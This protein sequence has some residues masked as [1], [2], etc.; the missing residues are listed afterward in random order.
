MFESK[1]PLLS[2]TKLDDGEKCHLQEI[3]ETIRRRDQRRDL[4]L[5]DLKSV[6]ENVRKNTQSIVWPES[7]GEKK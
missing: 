2:K 4:L 5:R 6:G 3:E 7:K 1:K